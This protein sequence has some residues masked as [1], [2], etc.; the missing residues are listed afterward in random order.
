MVR[1]NTNDETVTFKLYDAQIDSVLECTN[2]IVYSVSEGLG[3]V[4]EPYEFIANYYVNSI[5]H[6]VPEKFE[7]LKN[8]PNPFNNST[9]IRFSV[10]N[11]A[12]IQISVFD[13]AGNLV[14]VLVNERKPAGDY[15]VPWNGKDNMG[16]TCATGEYIIQMKNVDEQYLRKVLLIK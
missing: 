14:I 11:G 3:S 2:T 15:I 7:F 13:L 6:T 8:Y 5:A 16:N 9:N 12:L 4:D 1:S 10:L